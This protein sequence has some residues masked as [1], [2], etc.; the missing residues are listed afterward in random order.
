MG[1]RA[2]RRVDAVFE[3]CLG[4]STYEA[5]A[6]KKMHSMRRNSDGRTMQHQVYVDL[7]DTALQ[8]W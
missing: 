8:T 2:R 4:H 1:C 5:V 6:E 7:G 3:S